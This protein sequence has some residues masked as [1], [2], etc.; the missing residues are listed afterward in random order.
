[1]M[2]CVVG[3]LSPMLLILSLVLGPAGSSMRAASM[4]ATMAPIALSAMHSPGSCNDCAGGKNG[5][6]VS[7]CSIYCAGMVGVSPD[8]AAIHHSPPDIGPHLTPHL[9]ARH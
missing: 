8:L 6:P 4:I 2:A 5:V 1:M 9:L 7:A 3:R